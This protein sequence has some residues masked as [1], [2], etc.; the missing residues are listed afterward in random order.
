MNNG[1]SGYNRFS[2]VNFSED[3]LGFWAIVGEY[4]NCVK[5]DLIQ[6][7]G[8]EKLNIGH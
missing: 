4:L 3:F 8:S 5:N 7:C 2:Y 6:L 1:W